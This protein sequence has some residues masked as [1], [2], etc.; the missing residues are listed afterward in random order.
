MIASQNSQL[1]ATAAE[2][3]GSSPPV[4]RR[5]SLPS[6]NSTDRAAP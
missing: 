2:I 1:S 6:G 5:I 3:T 4:T